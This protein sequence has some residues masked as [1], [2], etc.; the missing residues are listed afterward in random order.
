MSDP[1]RI[2]LSRKKGWRKPADTVVVARPGKWGNPFPV[3]APSPTGGIVPNRAV[4]VALFRAMMADPAWREALR[5]P[6]DLSE[7]RDKNLACW[8]PLD[9]PCH[10]DVLLDLVRLAAPLPAAE[11]DTNSPA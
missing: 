4:S 6:A 5:Y 1:L 10:A 9:G 3:G 11:G 8:C 2:Q 7:L